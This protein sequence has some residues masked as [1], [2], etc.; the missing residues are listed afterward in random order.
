MDPDEA[1]M[2][3]GILPVAVIGV[4]GF[5]R[6][7]LAALACSGIV[8]VVGLADRNPEAAAQ[9]GR[10][11]NVPSYTDNRALLAQA[12]PAAVYMAVPPA[13]AGE[14]LSLC[15]QRGIHVW[16][17][18]PLARNL[19][20]G[21]AFVRQAQ[22]A[23]VKLA[24]GTQRRFAPGYRRAAELCP[25]LGQVFLGRAHYLFNWGP[26][27]KWRGD[28]ASAGGGAL[29]ELGYHPI[30]LLVWMLGLPNEVYGLSACGKKI[31]QPAPGDKVYPIYD[32]DDTAAAILRYNGGLMATVVTTRASGPV[33]EEIS[34]HGRGGSIVARSESC[35]LRDPDGNVLDN[36][37]D[38][39]APLDTFRRQVESFAQAVA[40]GAK[41]YECSALE[42]L[43][44]LAVLEAIYLSDRTAQSESPLRRLKTHDLEAQ[45]CL[46][47]R[48]DE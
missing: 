10:E 39:V 32:T 17:E 20:E 44:N 14:I 22:Q 37:S 47:Y 41:K 9:A 23:G 43:L 30:D 46:E 33:S 34:L 11:F 26:D 1:I 8:K 28:K 25:R 31:P 16:K 27:L 15:T 40:S 24:V 6:H 2:D 18:L 38:E 12:R 13:A 7:A 19:D 29:M 21:V 45:D 4:G 36:L 35:V 42:N 5:G 3:S 48:P